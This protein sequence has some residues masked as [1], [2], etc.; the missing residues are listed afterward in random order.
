MR[1]VVLGC[2]VISVR[3]RTFSL[4]F[5]ATLILVDCTSFGARLRKNAL[6]ESQ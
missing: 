1:F 6:S 2:I 3:A 4:N 5:T